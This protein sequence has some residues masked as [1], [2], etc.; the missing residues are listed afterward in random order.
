MKLAKALEIISDE[1]ETLFQND[2]DTLDAALLLLIEAGRR[3]QDGR[4]KG[5]DFFDLLLPGETGG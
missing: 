4:S 1:P 3:I 2:K 5:Y